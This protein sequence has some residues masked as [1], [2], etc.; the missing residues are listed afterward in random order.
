MFERFKNK[1]YL[2]YISEVKEKIEKQ[3]K[4]IYD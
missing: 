2:Q 1:E 4:K 3:E